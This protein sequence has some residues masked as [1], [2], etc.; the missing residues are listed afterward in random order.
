MTVPSYEDHYRPLEYKLEDD[1]LYRPDREYGHGHPFCSAAHE[2]YERAKLARE[3][4]ERFIRRE[5][6][7]AMRLAITVGPQYGK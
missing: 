2:A 7:N 5:A 3:S 1:P 6:E 4:V